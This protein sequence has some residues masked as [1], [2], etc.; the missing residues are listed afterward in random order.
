MKL[1]ITRGASLQ[2]MGLWHPAA[3]IGTWFGAGL[4]PLAP[5]TWGSLAALPF[6][7]LVQRWYGGFGLAVAT[8]LITV[9]GIWASDVLIRHLGRED[10][11]LVV[12]DEVA[13]MF[14]TLIAAPQTWWAYAIGFVLFRAADIVKPFPAGWCDT[15]LHGGLGAMLDDV[16]A[17]LW[18]LAAMWLIAT[19]VPVERILAAIG[20]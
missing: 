10:P 4:L 5:G 3:L 12:V 19:Y 14:L 6:A 2:G 11:G 13:G 8:V 17:A 7:W 9:V 18:S 20:L 15:R 16:A 1:Q